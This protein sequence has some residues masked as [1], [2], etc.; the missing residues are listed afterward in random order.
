MATHGSS[1]VTD[2]SW[3]KL[4][5]DSAPGA[6]PSLK[7]DGGGTVRLRSV[8]AR[9]MLVP[10]LAFT[11]LTLSFDDF[12]GKGATLDVDLPPGAAVSRFAVEENGAW[13]NAK[14]A[15]NAQA[16]QAI[17]ETLTGTDPTLVQ[18]GAARRFSARLLKGSGPPRVLLGYAEI[19]PSSQASYRVKLAGLPKL[20][21]LQVSVELKT[22]APR[23]FELSRK[24]FVPDR[25]FV[26]DG[27]ALGAKAATTELRAGPYFVLRQPADATPSTELSFLVDTSQSQTIPLDQL[28]DRLVALSERLA[29][30]SPSLLLS[31]VAFDQEVL[32][33]VIK[34]RAPLT[35]TLPRGLWHD[36]GGFQ[37]QLVHQ[38]GRAAAVCAPLLGPRTRRGKLGGRL[39]PEPM[40]VPVASRRAG[41]SAQLGRRGE[42][43]RGDGQIRRGW[44]RLR[45][46]AERALGR[47]RAEV[48]A[49]AGCR[50]RLP[51]SN[52]G[53]S[54]EFE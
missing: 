13:Q 45:Q 35:R 37:V 42:R 32:P 18:P 1:G 29:K 3:Q 51:H 25:D 39:L 24:G 31:V 52:H 50:R 41:R 2:L 7:A 28:S 47:R 30:L 40:P 53:A 6:P 17:G 34:A 5:R 44:L 15:D 43:A 21:G 54:Q 19:L 49:A 22:A 14:L 9:A 38:T 16:K 8:T 11:E 4:P 36:L 27:A 33:I 48:G 23:R 10:P 26:L 20:D 12:A 46:R